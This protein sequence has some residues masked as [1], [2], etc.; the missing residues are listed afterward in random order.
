M[1]RS[2][3]RLDEHLT[4]GRELYAQRDVLAG[5]CTELDDTYGETHGA[6]L[7]A[8]R[9]LGELDDLRDML[10]AQLAEDYPDDYRPSVYLPG[11][12]GAETGGE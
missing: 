4:L 5:R 2:K 11:A 10:D 1:S 9:V 12:T 6:A 8:H 7:Q 3:L